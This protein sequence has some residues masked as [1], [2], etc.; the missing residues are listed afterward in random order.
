MPMKIEELL[1]SK[2]QE[3]LA[4]AAK[5]GARNH[6]GSSAPWPEEKPGPKATLYILVEIE[7][8]RTLMDHVDLMHDL[9]ELLM[10]V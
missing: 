2:H 10:M 7:P 8:G 4:I 6:F 1:K 9:K 5:H 3:I